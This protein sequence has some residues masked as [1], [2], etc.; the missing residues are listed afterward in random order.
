MLATADYPER[1]LTELLPIRLS[2]GPDNPDCFG[3][4]DTA[5]GG[6]VAF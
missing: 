1:R 3:E 5:F 2:G 4:H 6:A